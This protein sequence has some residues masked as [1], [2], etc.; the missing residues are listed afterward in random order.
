MEEALPGVTE[1]VFVPADG[2]ADDVVGLVLAFQE[3]DPVA[4]AEGDAGHRGLDPLGLF[5]GRTSD[6]QAGVVIPDLEGCHRLEQQVDRR[7]MLPA[8]P[9]GAGGVLRRSNRLWVTV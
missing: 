8:L 4:V 7:L 1:H 3:E 6:D 9:V 5:D 2:H